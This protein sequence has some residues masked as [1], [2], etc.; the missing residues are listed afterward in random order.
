MAEWD[1]DALAEDLAAHLRG[2]TDRMVW[3]NMPMGRAGSVR[4][5]VW[6]L[7]KSYNFSALA[8]ECK[9]SVSD[10]R[11]DV[12]AGK[13]RSYLDYSSGVYFAVPQGLVQK[14]DIPTGCGLYVRGPDG[15]RGVRKPTLQR[16][17]ELP[18][19]VWMKLLMDGVKREVER[20]DLRARQLDS[21]AHAERTRRLAGDTLADALRDREAA[22][23]A[24]RSAEAR[25]LEAAA[26]IR[27]RTQQQIDFARQDASRLREHAEQVMS[28][29]AVS[30][31]LP[32]ESSLYDV[33]RAIRSARER[34]T[35]DGEV[36]A[37]TQQL[38]AIRKAL[39]NAQFPLFAGS[40]G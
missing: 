2:C 6:T 21:W 5:D 33:S 7:P 34:L 23:A 30:L 13:W 12:T 3:T 20:T 28:E 29:L 35:R 22:A 15:W 37:L 18:A 11:A 24:L 14:S 4:P 27:E 31:G 26:A 16:Q 8:Y 17:P 38:D 36:R 10:F 1:H 9:V 40:R 25:D 39:A 32:P 19:E